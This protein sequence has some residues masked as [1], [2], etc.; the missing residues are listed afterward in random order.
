[1][2]EYNSMNLLECISS[3]AYVYLI[4]G[5]VPIPGATGGIEYTYTNFFGVLIPKQ[6]LY[7]SLL[8]WRF[9]TYYLGMIIGGVVFSLEKKGE[10]WESEFLQKLI[11]HILVV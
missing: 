1:M 2:H 6:I 10:K 9:I 7:A 5:M 8:V 11:H 3:S 4:G